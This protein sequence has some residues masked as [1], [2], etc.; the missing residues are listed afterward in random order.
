MCLKMGHGLKTL[1]A[2]QP[3][4]SIALNLVCQQLIMF[5]NPSS[6]A[7]VFLWKI[8]CFSDSMSTTVIPLHCLTQAETIIL[9][10]CIYSTTLSHKTTLKYSSMRWL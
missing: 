4:Y 6:K 5:S 8:K 2:L 10:L 9:Y 7:S 1:E 3:K